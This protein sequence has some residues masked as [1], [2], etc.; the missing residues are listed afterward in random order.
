MPEDEKSERMKALRS[1]VKRND[2]QRW[3]QWFLDPYKTTRP[4]MREHVENTAPV[5]TP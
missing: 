4:P 2:V 1:E 3:V 5:K